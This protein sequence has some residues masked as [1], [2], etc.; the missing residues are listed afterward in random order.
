M[1]TIVYLFT[2]YLT[3]TL[4]MYWIVPWQEMKYR[5]TGSVRCGLLITIRESHHGYRYG[6]VATATSTRWQPGPTQHQHAVIVFGCVENSINQS[7][8]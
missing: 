5:Y 2:G 8:V 1:T 3:I 7:Q 4:L 6:R